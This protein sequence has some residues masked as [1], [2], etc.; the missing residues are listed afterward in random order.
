MQKG[1]EVV[2]WQNLSSILF[3]INYTLYLKNKQKLGSFRV[4]VSLWDPYWNTDSKKNN[5]DN[6]YRIWGMSTPQQMG[7][8]QRASNRGKPSLNLL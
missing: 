6:F 7:M 4:T 8:L 3:L 1:R 2:Q 5:S